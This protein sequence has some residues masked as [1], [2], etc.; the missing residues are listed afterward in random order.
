MA[1][2]QQIAIISGL[3]VAFLSDFLLAD[4]AES[5]IA[6]LWLDHAAWRWV[7]WVELLPA[8]IFLL[9]LLFI[10]E[11]PRFLISTGNEEKARQ[12]LRLGKRGGRQ[13]GG[14][15][16]HTGPG[17]QAAVLNRATGKVHGVVWVGIVVA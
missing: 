1:T 15:K 16:C 11:S 7:F 6:V 2:I 5:S 10:P 9:A 14:D 13:A 8:S 17:A 12:V 3:F 4:I